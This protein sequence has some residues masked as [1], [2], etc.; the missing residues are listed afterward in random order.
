MNVKV[1]HFNSTT[2]TFVTVANVATNFTNDLAG[3]EYAFRHTQ[4][5]DGSWS[6]GE[7]I[8]Y[9]HV[10]MIDNPDFNPDVEVIAPLPSHLG[11]TYG[12]RSSMV[13]DLF[14]VN[15]RIYVCASFGFQLYAP[16]IA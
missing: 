13:G 15:E 8:N 5:I 14:V 12:H 2:K 16:E 3:C 11:R 7:L 1:I 10:H 6:Q 9:D 4:N